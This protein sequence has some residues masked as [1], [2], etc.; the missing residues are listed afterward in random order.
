MSKTDFYAILKDQEA[1][2]YHLPEILRDLVFC[3]AN[4]SDESS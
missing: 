1:V 2:V 4:D 3:Q